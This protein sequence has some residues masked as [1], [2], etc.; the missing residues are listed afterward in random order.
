MLPAFQ[1]LA[2]LCAG[3]LHIVLASKHCLRST[4]C[5]SADTLIHAFARTLPLR[6]RARGGAA[7]GPGSAAGAAFSAWPL[8]THLPPPHTH[9]KSTG[10]VL[11]VAQQLGPGQQLEL[12]ALLGNLLLGDGGLPPEAAADVRAL[13]RHGNGSALAGRGG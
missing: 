11:E 3:A 5:H 6:Q 7:A 4:L 13:L 12:L 2:L 9:I 10:S 1:S 8:L